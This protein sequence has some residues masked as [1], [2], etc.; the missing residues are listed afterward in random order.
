[1]TVHDSQRPVSSIERRFSLAGRTAV[2]MGASG[3]IGGAIALGLAGAGARLALCFRR[4]ASQADRIAR[5]ARALGAEARTYAV[6]VLVAQE[7]R[8]H[9]DRVLDEF[10]TVDV[11]VNCAGGNV[12]AAMTDPS[13]GF[14][15]IDLGAVEDTMALNFTGGAVVPCLAYGRHMIAND[16]GG[17]I[18]NVT[19]MNAIRPLEGRPAYAAAKAAV[20]NFTQW[21]ATHIALEYTPRV[22]VNA[23]APG[24]FPN[25]RMRAALFEP[26]GTPNERGRKVLA[27]TPMRRFGEP[28]DLVGTAIWYASDASKFVTGTITP[29][30]GGFSAYSGV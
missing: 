17:S 19:S 2:V 11:L 29:V 12:K 30:D 10:G 18:I 13:S 4:N 7:Q 16:T 27:H 25:E 9:A 8:A 26:D 24:F 22:R 14:F 15:D 5:S 6:D 1:M 28:D 21:L 23:I 20:G 3:A